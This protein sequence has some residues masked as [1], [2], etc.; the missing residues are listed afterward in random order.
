MWLA[1]PHL[2]GRMAGLGEKM[3][4]RP[5]IVYRL[6][7]SVKLISESFLLDPIRSF[8]RVL[9]LL[10]GR[11]GA[12]GFSDVTRAS[13]Q[14]MSLFLCRNCFVEKARDSKGKRVGDRE[15]VSMVSLLA[16]MTPFVDDRLP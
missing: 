8:S 2:S 3:D 13:L 9:G 5:E 12:S 7:S 15:S 14:G 16:E 4:S 10:P 11:R 1:F 6:Q